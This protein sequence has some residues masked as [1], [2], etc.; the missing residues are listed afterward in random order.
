MSIREFN[1]TIRPV[2][3]MNKIHMGGA[4]GSISGKLID[5]YKRKTGEYEV[6]VFVLEKYFIRT[7]NRASMTV[8]IDNFEGATRAHSVI[9]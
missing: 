5:H 1:V 7:S 2:E 4:E 9:R 6:I 8:T 3:S